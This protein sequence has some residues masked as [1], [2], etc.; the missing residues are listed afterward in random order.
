MPGEKKTTS[1]SAT[2]TAFALGQINCQCKISLTTIKCAMPHVITISAQ[3]YGII[4]K[5]IINELKIKMP[6]T[7]TI[8]IFKNS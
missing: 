4:L 7:G 8:Y 3:A 2:L 6:I 1:A 5:R